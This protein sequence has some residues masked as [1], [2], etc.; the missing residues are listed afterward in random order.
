MQL[1]YEA[2]KQ[3][4]KLVIYNI[5]YE[6]KIKSQL[7]LVGSQLYAENIGSLLLLLIILE[8]F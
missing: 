5:I 1:N 6:R 2:L 3:Q 7:F 4:Q 8:Q